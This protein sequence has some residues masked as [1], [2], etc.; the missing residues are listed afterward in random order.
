MTEC[1]QRFVSPVWIGFLLNLAFE[2]SRIFI[3]LLTVDIGGTVMDVGLVGAANGLAFFAAAFV[4]GRQADIFG[5]LRFVRIGLGLSALAFLSQLVAFNVT[6]LLV[7]RTFVGFAMGITTGSLLVFAYE[8]RGGVGK[9]SS[10][11]ALGLIGGSVVSAIIKEYNLLFILS[12][13]S[14]AVAFFLSLRLEE[15]NKYQK[16]PVSRYFPVIWRNRAVY[17]PFFLRQLGASAIWIIF[18]LFLRELGADKFWI[19]MVVTANY[20]GQAV[21][22]GVVERFTGRGLFRL[23]LILSGVV[24][25]LYTVTAHVY[26]VLPVQVLLSGAWSLLY[27]EALVLLLRSGE[28]KGTATG[29]L[30]ASTNLCMALG[31]FLGGLLSSLWGFHAPMF[32]AAA[33][34]FAGLWWAPRQGRACNVKAL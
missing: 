22:M 20:A 9:F 4:F 10:F 25:L 17:L 30:V 13:L 18:P 3:P 19:A 8:N 29:I 24:F 31:P 34:S 6:A 33:L 27:I 14:S 26:H 7:V 12:F 21:L 5:R 23:G 11:G 1:R 28:E 15:Y 32:A 2:S 16:A